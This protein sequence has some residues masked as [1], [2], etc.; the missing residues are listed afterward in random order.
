MRSVARAAG[1]AIPGRPGL[2]RG[3]AAR[4]GA[5]SAAACAAAA[6]SGCSSASPS[7]YSHAG[8]EA[9][10]EDLVSNLEGGRYRRACEDLTAAARASVT[11]FPKGGCVGALAF[12]RGYLA[13]SGSP[14]LGVLVMKELSRVT[15]HVVI[16][17]DG[18]RYG[19]AIQAR[20]EFGRWRFEAGN[21]AGAAV[22]ARL[23]PS[24]E[25]VAR[26]LQSGTAQEVIARAKAG[27]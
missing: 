14:R 13:A 17:N 20:Y 7:T 1:G 26:T 10:R 18:A 3:W 9:A 22:M 27:E 15:P 11:V 4:C 24:L 5:V 8:I 19:S 12:A 2:R 6:V 21:D 25:Q 23:R 16:E